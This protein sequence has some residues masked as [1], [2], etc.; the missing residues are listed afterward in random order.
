MGRAGR[1]DT[2]VRRNVPALEILLGA[3]WV[4][5]SM[6]KGMLDISVVAVWFTALNVFMFHHCPEV[7]K[8]SLVAHLPS[9]P[10]LLVLCWNAAN[11]EGLV[12]ECVSVCCL[13]VILKSS[14]FCPL[15]IYFFQRYICNC[16][17]CLYSTWNTCQLWHFFCHSSIVFPFLFFNLQA[18]RVL[19]TIS[20][21]WSD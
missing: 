19:W 8:V 9:N 5:H 20:S 3:K 15:H 2:G 1:Y 11:V 21:V 18:T 13:C 10:S 7:V 12:G 14:K 17:F 4:S 16:R 6:L